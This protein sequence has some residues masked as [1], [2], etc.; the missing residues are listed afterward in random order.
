MSDPTHR[1]NT[2][3]D[4]KQNGIKL[5]DIKLIISSSRM[6]KDVSEVDSID[7]DVDA[8]KDEFAAIPD[9]SVESPL[10]SPLKVF[11]QG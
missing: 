9:G 2:K 11:G 1:E 4:I 5:N 6:E 8:M 3:R 10:Q 7:V